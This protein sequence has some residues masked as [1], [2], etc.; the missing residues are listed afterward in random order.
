MM[1]APG[2]FRAERLHRPDWYLLRGDAWHLRASRCSGCR[3]LIF[4]AASVC[5]RC[6]PPPAL[7]DVPLPETGR[8]LS[9]TRAE[10]APAA[11]R[12]PYTFGYADL[13]PTVRL[14]GQIEASAGD[15]PLA[16]DMQIRLV[17]GVVR[18]D[19]E[20]M[21]VWGYKFAPVRESEP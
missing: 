3:A 8:L 11:F 16:P 2:D 14:F 17:L 7:E 13:A 5:P 19:G 21:P 12:P 20:G 18:R 15:P 4:P 9:W 6:W 1:R 10:I